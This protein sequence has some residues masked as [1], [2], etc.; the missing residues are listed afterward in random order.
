MDLALMR[1]PSG[2]AWLG[3][4]PFTAHAVQPAEA[5]FYI[6]D[7][8]LQDPLPW[9]V[10][11]QLIALEPGQPLPA[12]L[13]PEA[14]PKVR[15]DKPRTEGFKMAFRR[16][17]RDVLADRLT[18]MVPVIT[19]AGQLEAGHWLAIL[20]TLLTAQNGGWGYAAGSAE[21]GF[22]GI[23]PELL[24]A[25][26]GQ[27]LQ[28]MALAGTAKPGAD[29]AFL[30]DVKEIDEHEIVVRFIMDQLKP[31]GVVERE[32]RG[33]LSTA[34]LR[35]FHTALRLHAQQPLQADALVKLLHPTPAVGCLPRSEW[36][37]QRL[38]EYRQLLQVPTFFGA[39]FGFSDG[40]EQRFV[41]CIRGIGW[42]GR[43]GCLPAGCGIVSGSAFDHEW[44]ELR[45]KRESVAKMLGI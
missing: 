37:L 21:E 44:R 5:A 18:K 36:W 16:I 45:L 33:L 41:V 42:A 22:L 13:V 7:F 30:E 14:L 26:K 1:E 28:T 31:L 39:P 27:Q 32:A 8:E 4:G 10:P 40:A 12:G 43:A 23:T 9:K 3:L 25:Q 6:N 38:H 11:A 17:R 34:G 20:P 24:F 15:W 19:Q 35:H 2:R 29:A